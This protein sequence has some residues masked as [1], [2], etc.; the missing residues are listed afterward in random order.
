M[1]TRNSPSARSEGRAPCPLA[2]LL[3]ACLT[4][5]TLP[6][7]AQ[8]SPA[9]PPWTVADRGAFYRVWQRTVPVTSPLTGQVLPVV[10]SYT[11]LG[12][13]MHFWSTNAGAGQWAESQDLIEITPT[14]AA[15]VH[16]QL[17]ASLSGD[18]T[19]AG[20]ITLTSP[21]GDVFSSHPL[22]L[23]YADPASGQVARIAPVQACQGVLYPPNI[24]VFSNVLAGLQADLMLVWTKEGFE[25]N[26]VLKEAPPL[27][28]SFQLSN[29]ACR[30]QFWTAFDQCP[31]PVEQRPA[32]LPSGLV[33]QILIFRDSWF[34][35]GSAFI[36]G[37]APLPPAGAAALVRPAS[38]SDPDKIPSAK[39]LAQ[40][41]GQTV[42][43][44]EVQRSEER[45][46]GKECR[47]RW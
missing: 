28:E 2:A 22:G 30:L 43:I 38:P 27:P 20:A 23:F 7:F 46:V 25:Q 18:I 47:S 36:V 44:E 13:G 5:S 26:L 41:G 4:F 11:E 24:L 37:N 35:V 8:T 21:S 19:G 9:D 33:D 17:Q 10:Q 6:A 29:A 3:C 32:T 40:I 1:E 15:A 16:G 31:V 14:G 34:P 12:N 45:R 42:L 39:S